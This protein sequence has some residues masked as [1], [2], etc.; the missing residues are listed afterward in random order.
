MDC[1]KTKEILNS[2]FDGEAHPQ[3]EN[4]KEHMRSCRACMEWYAGMEQ[5]I[6]LMEISGEDVPNVDIS[7]LV[8]SRLPERHPA[9]IRRSE[10][11]WSPKRTLAWIGTAWLVVLVS[12]A[13]VCITVPLWINHVPIANIV[14]GAYGHAKTSAGFIMETIMAFDI[15]Y[16]VMKPLFGGLGVVVRCVY[17]T[18]AVFLVVNFMLCATVTVIWCRRKITTVHAA[19][20]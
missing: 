20:I 11:G 15:L 3:A 6:A 4:A 5:A 2:I 14:V 17:P 9:N 8:M 1:R 19:L 7:P 18:M 10:T 12:I 16:K 13:L